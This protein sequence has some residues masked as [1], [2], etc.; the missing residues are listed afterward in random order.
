MMIMIGTNTKNITAPS[1]LITMTRGDS[2]V[3]EG[4]A[5]AGTPTRSDAMRR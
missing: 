4:G 2:A 1:T 5:E 3:G